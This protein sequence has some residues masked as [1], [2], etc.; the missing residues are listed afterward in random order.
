MTSGGSPASSRIST[1]IV[2]VC[3]TSSAGLKTH[4]FPQTSAGNIF[5][6][7]IAIGKLNGVMIPATQHV[8]AGRGRR[9]AP[10]LEAAAGRGD[11]AVHVLGGAQREAADDVP[12]VGRVD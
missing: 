3:G 9:A 5:H 2:P 12:R 7:G 4:A 11:R 1:S 6:V 10:H 8:A